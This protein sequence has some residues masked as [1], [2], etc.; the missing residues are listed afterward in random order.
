VNVSALTGL[1]LAA[2]LAA[3][4]LPAQ[5]E[6]GLAA[7]IITAPSAVI[8]LVITASIGN[9][10]GSVVNWYL[11]GRLTHFAD[12]WWFPASAE[13]LSQ[14]TNWYARYGR[15][16]LLLSWVPVIGDPLTLVAGLFREPLARFLLIVAIAKT[17]RYIV[18]ALIALNWV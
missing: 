2:F 14:A 5:S 7:L 15:W 16:S 1:F 18:V 12:R 11:G 10:M 8:G 3:T 9:I 4:I 6:A 13:R 17:G